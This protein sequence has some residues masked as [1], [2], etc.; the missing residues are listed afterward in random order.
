M[1]TYIYNI[2]KWRAC[3]GSYNNILE[4]QRKEEGVRRKEEGGRRKEEG[5]R[6]KE[7][8]GRRKEEGGGGKGP[9]TARRGHFVSHSHAKCIFRGFMC[10]TLTL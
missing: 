7:E 2:Y 9:G 8:G 10:L 3:P 1:Y 6:R 4:G 5:G